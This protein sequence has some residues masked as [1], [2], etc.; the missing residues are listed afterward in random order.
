LLLNE[1]VAANFATQKNPQI[2]FEICG[3]TIHYYRGPQGYVRDFTHIENDVHPQNLFKCIIDGHLIR[4]ESYQ[5]PGGDYPLL[6][7][8]VGKLRKDNQT[9]WCNGQVIDEDLTRFVFKKR[10]LHWAKGI[11]I[12]D[13]KEY[14][15][16]L[17]SEGF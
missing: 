5:F 11:V 3:K 13:R 15:A 8:D 1:T 12:R 16:K 9:Y 4:M 2:F 10:H 14:A 6:C 7:N 17:A